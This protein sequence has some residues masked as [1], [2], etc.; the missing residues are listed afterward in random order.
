MTKRR[1]TIGLVLALLGVAAAAA[2]RLRACQRSAQ[3]AAQLREAVAR[4][5]NE[6]GAPAPGAVAGV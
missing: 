1:V 3:E 2:V 6:G 5:E 4:F